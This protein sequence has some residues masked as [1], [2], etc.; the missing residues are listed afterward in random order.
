MG[1]RKNEKKA[2]TQQTAAIDYA[3]AF[4]SYDITPEEQERCS[5]RRRPHMARPGRYTSLTSTSTSSSRRRRR[6]RT[7]SRR[8]AFISYDTHRRFHD[9]ADA[10]AGLHG[11]GRAPDSVRTPPCI[12]V[13]P[14]G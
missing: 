14:E 6:K 7:P 13:L 4:K 11:R 2:T 1:P 5:S 12:P 10:H 8:S 3:G 9:L